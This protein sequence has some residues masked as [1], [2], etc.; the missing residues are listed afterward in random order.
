M[1]SILVIRKESEIQTLLPDVID[2]PLLC[3]LGSKLARARQELNKGNGLISRK[4]KAIYYDIPVIR[5]GMR[6][7]VTDVERNETYTGVITGWRLGVN[8][9]LDEYDITIKKVK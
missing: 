5:K 4:Y 8:G 9:N 1:S 3:T 6:V 2:N 7:K